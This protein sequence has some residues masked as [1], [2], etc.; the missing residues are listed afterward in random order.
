MIVTAEVLVRHAKT[1]YVGD[2]LTWT[3]E[4][5]SKKVIHASSVCQFTAI[6]P[7]DAKC[8]QTKDSSQ[9]NILSIM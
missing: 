9:I 7:A 6:A 8:Q 3:G 5:T 1:N 4:A 2:R